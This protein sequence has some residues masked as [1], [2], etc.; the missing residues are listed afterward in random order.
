MTSWRNKFYTA[1]SDRQSIV[2]WADSV[3]MNKS[4][5]KCSLAMCSKLSSHETMKEAM[6][7]Q[8]TDR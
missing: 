3:G 1:F 8:N 5:V 7:L 2:L 6:G 4:P